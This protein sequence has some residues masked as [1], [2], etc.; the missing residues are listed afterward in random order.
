[1]SWAA[2]KRLWTGSQSPVVRKPRPNVE[3]AS[4]ASLK[5]L[6]AS[7]AAIATDARAAARASAWSP[8]SPRRS[9]A[10]RRRPSPAA[11]GGARTPGALAT[12][13]GELGPVVGDHPLGQRPVA[14]ALGVGLPVGDRVG[15]ALPQRR[16]LVAV[17]GDDH[18]G[19]GR[20]GPGGGGGG[21]RVHDRDA[22][23]GHRAR[24]GRRRL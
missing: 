11:A 19:E 8:W 10:P 15:D 9:S 3:I 23:R 21:R 22:A 5:T 14:E 4:L 17:R 18:V 16:G 24:G 12:E 2:P 13:P 6:K 20:V 1:M 7:P